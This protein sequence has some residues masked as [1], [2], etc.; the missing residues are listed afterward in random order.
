MEPVYQLIKSEV[1]GFIKTVMKEHLSEVRL[2]VIRDTRNELE[3][4]NVS[5]QRNISAFIE[6][7]TDDNPIISPDYLHSAVTAMISLE[8]AKKGELLLS[9]RL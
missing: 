5:G 3:T 9:Q 1:D 6:R 2:D 8:K 4:L 7:V